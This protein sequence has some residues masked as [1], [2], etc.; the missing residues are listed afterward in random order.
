MLDHSEKIS[1]T[2]SNIKMQRIH[3]VMVQWE[4]NQ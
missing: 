2:F 3:M 4:T 1:L